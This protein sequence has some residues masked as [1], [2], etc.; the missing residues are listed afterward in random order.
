MSVIVEPRPVEA[1]APSSVPEPDRWA[2]R[3][4]LG[5]LALGVLVR[6][7]RYWLRF[8]F[9][10]DET[11]LAVNFVWFDYAQLTQG[12]ENCQIA[13]LLFLWG[14]RAAYGWLGS[15]EWSLRLVPL[16]AGCVALAHAAAPDWPVAAP[17]P[18]CS[19]S[20]FWPWRTCPSR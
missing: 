12:L 4:A 6:A 13:P 15:G 20:A 18:G 16:L 7:A 2:Y 9:W 10:G 5:L 14:E 1:P 3:A 17:G 11:M 8:P 19:P